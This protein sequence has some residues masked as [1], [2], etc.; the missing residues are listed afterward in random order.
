MVTWFERYVQEEGRAPHKFVELD[1]LEVSTYP[2]D[3]FFRFSLFLFFSVIT[4][5]TSSSLH[6]LSFTGDKEESDAHR[7]Q[8]R[9]AYKAGFWSRDIT[10]Y[11]IWHFV[12]YLGFYFWC[13]SFCSLVI[14]ICKQCCLKQNT[15]K[16]IIYLGLQADSITSVCK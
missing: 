11:T 8:R 15:Y 7:L 16:D 10:R 12:F 4:K 1:F 6:L 9:L 2:L 13:M 14:N 3:F 5:W